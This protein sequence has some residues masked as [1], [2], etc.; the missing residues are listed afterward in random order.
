M[1]QE[2]KL[3]GKTAGVTGASKGIGASIAKR[4][5]AEGAAVVVK[6]ASS[7]AGADAV[8]TEITVAGGRALA[9]QADVSNQADIE[10]LF[11]ATKAA[12]GPVDTAAAVVFLALPGAS[13]M[14]WQTLCIGGGLR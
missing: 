13:W 12:F 8:V 9:V 11:S 1:S 6:Y 5:A 10:R 4:L 7:K 2:L 3:A 14:T